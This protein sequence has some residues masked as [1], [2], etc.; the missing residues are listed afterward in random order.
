[1]NTEVLDVSPDRADLGA[2]LGGVANIEKR[3]YTPFTSD[4]V[5]ISFSS[6]PS[7]SHLCPFLT[8]IPSL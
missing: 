5:L 3:N 6:H 7:L 2:D 1:M 8:S 4:F